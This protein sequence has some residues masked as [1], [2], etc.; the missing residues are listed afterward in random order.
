MKLKVKDLMKTE[1]ETLTPDNTLQDAVALEMRKHCQI[2]AAVGKSPVAIFKLA[3]GQICQV[4]L[5]IFFRC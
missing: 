2:V 1:L 3:I 4:M 5:N